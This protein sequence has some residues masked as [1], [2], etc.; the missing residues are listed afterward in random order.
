M[1][2][3]INALA[4]ACLAIGMLSAATPPMGTMMVP[5]SLPLTWTA[6]VTSS[7]TSKAGSAFGQGWVAISGAPVSQTVALQVLHNGYQRQRRGAA[8]E[9][10]R[11]RKDA[12]LFPTTARADWQRRRLGL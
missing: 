8:I 4:T 1:V 2:M 5:R 3:P 11:L 7:C 9:L 10:A 12:I 6:M